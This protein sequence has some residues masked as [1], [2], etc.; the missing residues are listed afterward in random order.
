MIS[1]TDITMTKLI[2][3]NK[4]FWDYAY[5]QFKDNY[6]TSEYLK[7][8]ENTYKKTNQTLTELKQIKAEI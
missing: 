8:L 1:G 7:D 5:E 4:I 2:A 3:F 6:A